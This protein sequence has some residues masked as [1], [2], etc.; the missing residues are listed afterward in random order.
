[1]ASGSVVLKMTIYVSYIH[2]VLHFE[3]K[4]QNGSAKE[5]YPID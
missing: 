1:M 2:F 3:G 5:S 4:W